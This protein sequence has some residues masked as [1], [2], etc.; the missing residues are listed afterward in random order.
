LL[1]NTVKWH[2]PK[3][4]KDLWGFGRVREKK[5]FVKSLK[6]SLILAYTKRRKKRP[7]YFHFLRFHR[8]KRRSPAPFRA[9]DD[10]KSVKSQKRDVFLQINLVKMY[11]KLTGFFWCK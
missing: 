11:G 5:I 2:T 6:G 10:I 3:K 1:K 4:I 9:Y 8:Y 7:I